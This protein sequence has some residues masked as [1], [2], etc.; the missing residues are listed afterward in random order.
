MVQ[1][2]PSLGISAA[3]DSQGFRDAIKF[4]MQMG[5]NPNPDR[6]PIFVKRSGAATYWKNN[7]QL[8][9]TPRLDRDGIPLDPDVEVRREADQNLEVDCAIEVV[10]AEAEELPVGNFRPTKV[11]ATL[12]DAEYALVQGC[13][14]L[15]YNGDRYVFGYEPESN[16]LFDV[17][18]YTMIFYAKDES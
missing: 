8:S 1:P 10:R 17:G 13:R 15:L 11:V 12:L 18:V 9:T 2:D 16:G 6:R 7:V 3:F 4:A 14:E 5:T